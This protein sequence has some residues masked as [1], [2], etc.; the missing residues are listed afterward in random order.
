MRVRS[1]GQDDP[2]EEAMTTL[3]SIPAWRIPVDRGAWRRRGSQ[4]ASGAAP[5]KSGLHARG[6]GERVLALESR[7]GTRAPLS[8][9]I[10]Q[11][12][13]L[14]WVTMPSSFRR[15]SQ[16]PGWGSMGGSRNLPWRVS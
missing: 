16:C 14:E 7:E 2:L 10:L 1:L 11:A 4:G 12:G 5:G 6:E 13:I 15:S 8:T 9:G 3:S